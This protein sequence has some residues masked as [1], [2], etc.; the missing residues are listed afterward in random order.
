MTAI[1]QFRAARRVSVP[2]VIVQTPDFTSFIQEVNKYYTDKDVPILQ[3]DIARGINGVNE[4]GGAAAA[5][6]NKDGSGEPQPPAAATGNPIEALQKSLD[7]LPPKSILFMM[8]VQILLE[9]KDADRLGIIQSIWNCRDVFKGSERKNTLVLLCPGIQIPIELTNDVITIDVP[10]PDEAQL[11]SIV[12]ELVESG[13]KAGLKKPEKSLLDQAI[14]AVSGLSAFAAEQVTAMAITP[15]GMDIQSM[16]DR[17]RSIIQQV[18]GLTVETRVTSFDELGGLDRVKM[19]LRMFIKGKKKPKLVVLLD[20]IDRSLAGINDSS[21]VGG[22]SY[23]QLLTNLQDNRWTGILCP[24]FGGTGKTELAHAMGCE[25]G[26]LFI[27]MDLGA[28]QSKYVGE[29]QKKIRAAFQILK[30]MGGENVFFIATTNRAEAIRPELKSRFLGGTFFFD[31][32]TEEEQKPIWKIYMKKF[33]VTGVPSDIPDTVGWTGREIK[34]CC[35]LSD[36][37]SIP[38]KDAA[39]YVTPVIKSMGD[40]VTKLRASAHQ[41]YLSASKPSFYTMPAPPQFDKPQQRAIGE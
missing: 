22:D 13:V 31:L 16:W 12:N 34:G 18:G 20:E 11:R 9:A 36:M 40:D 27:K 17:K 30:A 41:K 14:D 24:G 3:W 4:K 29:S 25:A 33:T 1:E 6:I 15:Q 28:A 38:L 21:G 32:P 2:I 19:F 5:E 23:Q 7:L 39:T 10:L 26:G 8:N 37:L 35:E